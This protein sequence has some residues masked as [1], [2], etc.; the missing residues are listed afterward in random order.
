MKR[1]I[2]LAAIAVI[3]LVAKAEHV[4]LHKARTIAKDFF[5]DKGIAFSDN[6]TPY[7][8]PR[9]ASKRNDNNHPYYVFN[10]GNDKGYVI[11]SGDDRTAQVLGYADSGS[12]DESKMP[13]N[14][15]SWMQFYADKIEYICDNNISIKKE[16]P[17][18][19]A[20]RKAM[21]VHHSITPILKCKWN[22]SAPY[23]LK[24][25]MYYKEDG[26]TGEHSV[27]GCVATAI[28][29][30][31]YHHKYPDATKMRIP[32]MS[33]KYDTPDGQKT[34]SLKGIEKGTTIDWASMCDN[35]TGNETQ[36]QKD[37]VAELMLIV[38]QAMKMQYG[39]ISSSSYAQ[40]RQLL[41][42]YLGFDDEVQVLH[43]NDYGITEWFEMMY[44]ELE[45]G[46]PIAYGGAS[47]NGGHA[48][49]VDGFD[50]DEFFH[51]NWGWG[52]TLDGYFRID[53]LNPGDNSGI[54]A[55]SSSDGYSMAQDA[56][57]NIRANDNGIPNTEE[58]GVKAAMENIKIKGTSISLTYIN[59]TGE[60]N[61]FDCAIVMQNEQGVLTPLTSIATINSLGENYYREKTFY[62]SGK[63]QKPGSYKISPANK[64]VG[65]N[66]WRTA[67]DMRQEYILAEVDDNLKVT[68]TKVTPGKDLEVTSWDF[69]G[70]L[71]INERQNVN[72]TLKNNGEEFKYGLN[73]YASNT[74]DMGNSISRAMICLKAGESDV[75]TF[76]FQP[77]STGKWHLWL[78]ANNDKNA[79]IGETTVD[80]GNTAQHRANLAVNSVTINN[81]GYSDCLIGT[82]SVKN[83][84][85][86]PFRGNVYLVLWSNTTGE[87][88]WHY[89]TF[90]LIHYEIPAESSVSAPFVFHNLTIGKN[91]RF[92]QRY[93]DQDGDLT[94]GGLFDG[95][96]W[97][98][99]DGYLTWGATG[100]VAGGAVANTVSISSNASGVLFKGVNIATVNASTNPNTIYAFTDGAQVP[101]SLVGKNV[102][103]EGIA[104]NI[105]LT[106]NNTAYFPVDC[107]ASTASFSFTFSRA[108]NGESGWEALTLPF[109]PS[110]ITMDGTEVDWKRKGSDGKF[111]LR[112]FSELTDDNEVVFN[113]VTSIDALRSSTPYVIAAPQEY[114]GKTIVF[115]GSDVK[116]IN[117][118][119]DNMLIGSQAFRFYGNTLKK[120]VGN[121]FLMNKT[122]DA[123]E[124]TAT[125]KGIA[126][127]DNYFEWKLSEQTRPAAIKISTSAT[128]IKEV[129]DSTSDGY[130]YDLQG[131]RVANPTH[132]LYIINGKKHLIK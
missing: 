86:K 116:F 22:Q 50:G 88:E 37:A 79:V 60:T 121:V 113:D 54:G 10:A 3:T 128:G 65:N 2:V 49:V 90:Q 51:L 29:Q 96:Q 103:N 44:D 32:P 102:V 91:Y 27:T 47:T 45:K 105:T 52:G 80:I 107:T 132:G 24:C 12:F 87:K 21:K 13:E 5:A 78:T 9:R 68:L 23:N 117:S 55:S 43:S 129:S 76:F 109:K 15:R 125:N 71:K 92:S 93:K 98:V 57:I 85:K 82:M 77:N 61:S 89:T 74:D 70:T 67:Y 36:A 4:D 99:K 7:K 40:A 118:E 112:E 63:F 111:W 28:A 115:E 126:P 100:A 38:G 19:R 104:E 83:N 120:R 35:Y 119:N 46:Y 1:F 26:T 114:V 39:E 56:I 58:S 84:S 18:K 62:L 75:F 30:V 97:Q 11:V 8:A 53:V 16:S 110:K 6:N 48:F 42:N 33:N 14:M 20:A 59:W 131:R 72:I 64:L 95:D 101:A 73:L 94:G 31:L 106:D 108:G 122:G 25:P 41:V 123:Y 127:F 130:I 69:P 81:N 124:Y 17:V 34:V 66:I